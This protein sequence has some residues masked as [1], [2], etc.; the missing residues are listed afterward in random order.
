MEDKFKKALPFQ[1]HGVRSSIF[2]FLLINY[3]LK[4]NN[5][6]PG[7]QPEIALLLREGAK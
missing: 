2:L 1:I 5:P 6:K 3:I 7:F 4:N